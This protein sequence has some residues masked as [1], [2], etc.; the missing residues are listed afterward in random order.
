MSSIPSIALE[1]TLKATSKSIDFSSQPIVRGF[2]FNGDG[3]IDYFQLLKSF[4]TTGFQA[5]H[6]GQAVEQ[7]ESM[8]KSNATI[9]LGYTSNMVSSGCRE[10][11]RYLCQHRLVNAIV[12]TAGGI[13]EDFIKCLAPSYVGEFTFKGENLRENGLNRIGNLLVPNDNYCR[14][15]DWL[16]PILNRIVD[17]NEKNLI[18]TPSELIERLASEIQNE[19]SIYYWCWKN[20]IPVFCPAITDGSLGDMLYFHSYRKP[21]LKID[22]LQDLKRINTIAVEAKTSGMLILGGGIVKHHICTS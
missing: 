2:D 15:E 12:T 8:L 13:E 3:P 19:D 16:T 4:S 9:F 11:L 18:W 1:A 5:T 22:I 6:F 7:I 21:G 14:F 17:Q 20:S 10:I